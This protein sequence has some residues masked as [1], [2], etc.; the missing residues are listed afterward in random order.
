MTSTS[1][2]KTQNPKSKQKP[3][4]KT[5]TQNK[6]SKIKTESQNKKSNLRRDGAVNRQSPLKS[7]SDFNITMANS[8]SKN[9][10]NSYDDSIVVKDATETKKPPEIPPPLEKSLPGDC[11]GSGCVR[12]IWDVYY[13]E[14]EE[15]SVNR[16]WV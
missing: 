8:G 9:K 4:Q 15:Y 11:C 1:K 6:K 16:Y 14:L 13:D 5:R 2:E 3:I 12:R 7:D 10:I